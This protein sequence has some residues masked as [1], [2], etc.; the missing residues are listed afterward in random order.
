[1]TYAQLA[2]RIS[3]MAR[4]LRDAGVDAGHV[5]V[6]CE[7]SI[8]GIVAMLAVLE[9]GGVYVPL[10]VSLPDSRHLDIVRLCKPALVVF[11]APTEQRAKRLLDAAGVGGDREPLRA[12]E[13][14]MDDSH[15]DLFRDGNDNGLKSSRSATSP[16]FLLFT[17]GSTGT[18]N[19]VLL[20]QANFAN[21]V[22]LKTQAF[23]ITQHDCVLQQSSLGFD[24]ALIQTFSALANGARLVIAPSDIR[25]D[26]VALAALVRREAVSMTIATPT[27]YLAW[28]DAGPDDLSQAD[29]WR[30]VFSG[31]EQLP[32][33]LT[34]ELG[35]L[36]IPG[37]R[38]TNCY[39]PTE[40]TA[41]ASFQPIPLDNDGDGNGDGNGTNA[42]GTS[43]VVS[44]EAP[45]AV[46]RPYAVGKALP[47]Y[48]VCII[49]AAG[50]PQPLGHT[51]EICI[52]GA[53]VALGYLNQPDLTRVRFVTGIPGMAGTVYRTGDKGRLLADGTL[54]C[55]GRLDGDTQIKL[56]GQRIDLQEVEAAVLR[57][58]DDAFAS[59]VVSRRRLDGREDD[60]LIAHA[61]LAGSKSASW[62]DENENA[63]VAKVLSRVRLPQAFIPAAVYI[64]DTMPTT[65]NGKLDRKE[66]ARLPLPARRT[67]TADHRTFESGVRG[68]MNNTIIT[69]N[70][71]AEKLTVHQGELRLLWER[72]LPALGDKRIGPSSD[73]FLCGGNS[74]LLMKLQ[75]AVKETTGVDISTKRMYE[76]TTLRAMAHA[77]FDD[78][79]GG[80]G[81][82]ENTRI[83]WEAET[84]VPLWLQD[85]IEHR[86]VE[87]STKP[88]NKM[89]SE[90]IQVLL[91][92]A[93]SFPGS[94][95]LTAL[96][97]HPAVR[98][99]HC[100]TMPSDPVP[101]P[102]R[103]SPDS[104]PLSESSAAAAKVAY[105]TGSLLSPTLG[106]T[107][108][109][110]DTLAQTV[111]VMVHAGAHGHCLNRFTT[112]RRPN[113]ESLHLLASMALPRAIPLLFLSSP[114]CL[115]LAGDTDTPRSPGS[116]REFQ[117]PVD[118]SDGYTASK[119]AGE[120]FLENLTS[121]MNNIRNAKAGTGLKVAVHRPCTL[122]S[123]QAPN[124]D[125]MNGILRYSLAMRCVPRLRRAEGFLDFSQLNVVVENIVTAAV[126]LA[127]PGGPGPADAASADA[128]SSL[129]SF[130]HHSGGVKTPFAQFRAHMETVY[131]GEFT[132]V[133]MEEWLV[134]AG[135]RGL[136]PLITAYIEA[137]LESGMPLVSPY[138]GAQ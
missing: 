52:G 25:R 37:M 19:G 36:G 129:I 55:L 70:H 44:P 30:L 24:M 16:S 78:P 122:V 4:C 65:P 6:L 101:D 91:T 3:R 76:A 130:R 9:A 116:L 86:Q 46:W 137:L 54:L 102:R 136:D 53:G 134:R 125:A 28:I 45:S 96:L 15:D 62:D 120:V 107:P 121:H 73:F 88:V 131:G 80:A 128:T 38:L 82:E 50:L 68:E 123:D 114:R 79:E 63:G 87:A 97:R 132:E 2:A 92:G 61:T 32:P 77:V 94:H 35:R 138:L 40:I 84:A 93:T 67:G 75:R 57:A 18:P 41:A 83:D 118:G 69:D 42:R 58:A 13:V 17:S 7:P 60:V 135:R 109:E 11:H 43:C 47:N 112:L 100:I 34:T 29:A 90:G 56:R 23:G 33:R 71:A 48:T 110:R 8:E 10:D 99:V 111:D 72:V 127:G 49:N 26:P 115:L 20:T 89:E 103:T 98:K 106:L 31:G 74:L 66:I 108:A 51:G 119:W 126:Q 133:D 104:L 22:A 117:P 124:S 81:R 64:L 59:V 39:G 5:V 12:V 1:M 27:E 113:L 21:H 85:Q 95:I 14:D 105:Y